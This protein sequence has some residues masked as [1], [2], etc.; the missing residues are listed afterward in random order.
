MS[1]SS[2]VSSRFYKNF[3][4]KVYG[5]GAALVI[6]G[7]LFKINHYTGADIMLI[8]GLTTEALIF[9]FSAF[10]PPHVEP[11][12]SLVY[13]ELAGMYHG[14]AGTPGAAPRKGQTG[15]TVSQDLDD[16]L[17]KAK[18][19]PELIESL[20]DGMR[21]MSENVGKMSDITST[22][23]ATDEFTKSVKD[24][25][26]SA[27]ELSS[28]YKKTAEVLNQDAS[29]VGEFSNSVKSAATSAGTL[30]TVYT[31]VSAA[32]KKEMS[33]TEQFSNTMAMATESANKLAQ[34]Y[35]QSAELLGKSAEAL[36]FSA[37]DSK[38]YN[39][40]LQKISKNLTALNA[41]YELQLQSSNE[42]IESTNKLRTTVN[43]FLAS[44]SDSSG[45]MT[46][47]KEEIDQLTKRVSALNQVYGNM[48]TAMNVNMNK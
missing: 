30:A 6:M 27:G 40:Q 41:I 45:N 37:L 18:I 26:K 23:V 16:M 17:S 28:S 35:N 47:Y 8:I 4:S 2:F 10:E 15:K 39:E 22:A 12:W 34:K 14:G 36:N 29:T 11:D 33:A 24:A 44:M 48:L 25:S 42:Q 19:G 21:K 46:K 7:A 5:W 20:G 13:P 9:F 32:I 3:M 38:S 31:E 43:T 1:L